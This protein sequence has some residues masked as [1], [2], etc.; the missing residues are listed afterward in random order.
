MPHLL[1]L[2]MLALP[3]AVVVELPAAAAVSPSRPAPGFGFRAYAE[4]GNLLDIPDVG[5][6]S[7]AGPSYVNETRLQ[8]EAAEVRSLLPAI[9]PGGFNAFVLCEFPAQTVLA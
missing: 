1:A 8:S 2:C 4:V 9:T 3:P 7:D 6:Y 5:Y